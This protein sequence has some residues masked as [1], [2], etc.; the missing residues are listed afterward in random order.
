LSKSILVSSWLAILSTSF[1]IVAASPPVI[2]VARSRTALIVNHASVPGVATILN[3]TLVETTDTPSN[4]NLANGEQIVL[5]PN[6]SGRV[7]QERLILDRGA[8]E[9]TG[10]SVYRIETADFRVGTSSP[11]SHIQVALRGAEHIHVEAFGGA[12]E[13]SNA[14]GLLVANVL[15]GTALELQATGA[16]STQLAGIVRSRNGRFLLTDEVSR[17]GVELRGANLSSFV[18]KQV[19]IVGSRIPDALALAGTSQVVAISKVTLTSDN[20]SAGGQSAGGQSAGGQSAGGQSA[21]GSPPPSPGPTP[22]NNTSHG[23]KKKKVLLVVVGG[24]AV[25]GGTVGG[26]YAAGTI[27][28]S[29]P[30]PVS[31]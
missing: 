29:G 27:G 28:G 1:A 24:A 26:L 19:E 30:S 10:S 25:V 5:A 17:V 16:T 21:G 8:A 12:G 20:D 31:P 11:T 18:N 14:Q 22:S 15:A 3:G 23:S 6:S 4:L 9:F 7:Q 2:G 13:V